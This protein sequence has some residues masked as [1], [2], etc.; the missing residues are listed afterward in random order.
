MM[1]EIDYHTLSAINGPLIFIE[2]VKGVGYGELVKVTAL[3]P[4]KTSV[5]SP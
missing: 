3:S 4:G 2:G 5:L 1:N